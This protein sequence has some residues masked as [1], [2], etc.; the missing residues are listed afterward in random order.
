MFT[1]RAARS[2]IIV[3]EIS[4]STSINIL[5]GLDSGKVSA[6]LKAVEAVKARDASEV[7]L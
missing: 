6:G 5:A 1:A 2:T 4:D 7:L 3:I